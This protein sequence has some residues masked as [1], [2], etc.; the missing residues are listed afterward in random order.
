M[1]VNVGEGGEL[2]GS[3]PSLFGGG[4]LIDFLVR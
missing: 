2:G 3:P 4:Y 1:Q